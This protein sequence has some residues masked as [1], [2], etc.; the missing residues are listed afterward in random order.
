LSKGTEDYRPIELANHVAGT[1][2]IENF[3]VCDIYS[4]AIVLFV[5][6]SG[7]VLPF[8]EQDE[9]SKAGANNISKSLFLRNRQRFWVLHEE[10]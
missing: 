3:Q 1:D 9:K 7:G 8:R 2:T 6:F 5:M 4:A 10:L